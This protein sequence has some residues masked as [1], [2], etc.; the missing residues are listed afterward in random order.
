MQKTF[1][2]AKQGGVVPN[3][4]NTKKISPSKI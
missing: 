2:Q 3:K 1:Y 4:E